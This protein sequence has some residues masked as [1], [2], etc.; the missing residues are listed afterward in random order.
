MS[1]HSISIVPVISR[2]PDRLIKAKEILEWL[3]SEDIVKPVLSDCVLGSGF[4]YA[5][6]EGA[7]KVTMMPEQLPFSLI[8]NGLEICTERTIFH[9]GQNGME[10]CICP[11][12]NK[13]I[14]EEDWS[15]FNHWYEQ[16]SDDLICP[17]CSTAAEIH[18]YRFS[19][20]WGF[21]DLGFTF[22]NWPDLK[23][24][25]IESFRQKIGSEIT[26]VYTHI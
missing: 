22:W 13:N 21:S 4:G 23:V 1:D 19:P 5:V 6:S 10:K 8:T 2:Y 7:K 14:A 26:V 11:N 25:F 3:I 20:E 9:T 16:I 15:F 12:C 17:V 18:S 24:E